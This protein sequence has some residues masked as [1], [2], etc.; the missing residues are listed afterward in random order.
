MQESVKLL[1][2][3]AGVYR[4][5]DYNGRLL[6]VGKAK[7]LKN[8]V[9]SYFRFTP[10]FGSS[11]DVSLRISKMLAEAKSLEWTITSCEADALVLENSLIKQLRPKYNILLRDDKTYPYIVIDYEQDYPR[12]EITRKTISGGKRKYY[13]P[14]VSS[15]RELL[16]TIY[17]KYALVQKKACLR[18]KKAC[19][20]YQI[21]RLL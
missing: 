7:S 14:F 9:K 20:F 19:L 3:F 13:G 2:D 6:Y 8:R 15:A 18:G 10:E 4:F 16:A 17:E 12:L 5:Y 11:P 1:P 21:N